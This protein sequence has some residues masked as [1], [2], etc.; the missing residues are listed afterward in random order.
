MAKHF[1]FLLVL[2]GVGIAQAQ[3]QQ[4]PLEPIKVKSGRE[5][6]LTEFLSQVREKHIGYRAADQSVQAAELQAKEAHLQTSPNFFSNAQQINDAKPSVLFNYSRLITTSYQVGVSQNT[7]YGLLGKFY[8]NFTDLQYKGLAYGTSATD[9]HAIQVA[10]TVE[11]TLSLW[12]NF[13]GNE[14]RSLLLQGD[15]MASAKKYNESFKMKNLIVQA[16]TSYWTLALARESVIVSSAAVG[17]AQ[18]MYDWHSRRANLGLGDRSDFLQAQA[19]LQLRKL[20]LRKAQDDEKAAARAF[21]SARGIDAT[22]VSEKLMTFTPEKVQQF[23]IPDRFESRDDVKA[24]YELARA[25]RAGAE[26][27]RQKQLPTLELYGA[28]ATNNPTPTDTDGAYGNS[29]RGD[30]PT[31]TVGV[32]LN[33]PLDFGLVSDVRLGYEKD[34]AAA[35]YNYQRKLFDQETDWN[36]LAQ[37][38][39]QAKERFSLYQ[40]LEAA[41]KTKLEYERQRRS[42]GLTTTQQVINFEQ[43]YEQAQLGRIRTLSEMLQLF[44]QMKMYGVN[45]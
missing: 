22:E 23:Q 25:N 40:D 37:K 3:N 1:A 45:Q 42:K 34:K 13:L 14:T 2:L 29:F 32:R 44:A 12:R 31:T 21:N 5:F 33:A 24:A 8:Y 35:D 7:K 36:D 6:S 26:A 16:E 10:P 41:Q 19:A 38:F 15:A 17:R 43:E 4:P 11:M 9:V 39:L 28:A 30:R 20:D 27:A 18:Q